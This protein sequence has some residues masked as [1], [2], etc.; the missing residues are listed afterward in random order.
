MSEQNDDIEFMTRAK[1]SKLVEQT[2]REYQ[3]SHM[4]AV[5]HLC[6]QYQIELEDCKKFVSKV[7]KEKLEVEAM[8]LNFLEKSNSLP[9]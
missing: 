1:F 9:I 2:V 8:N 5:I 7:I 4:D 3:M 6:E